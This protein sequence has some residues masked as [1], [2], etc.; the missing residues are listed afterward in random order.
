M[1]GLTKVRRVAN[2][3]HGFTLIGATVK[4]WQNVAYVIMHDWR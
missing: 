2:L 1:C 3:R 4:I